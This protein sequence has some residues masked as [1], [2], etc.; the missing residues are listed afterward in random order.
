MDGRALPLLDA[1][2]VRAADVELDGHEDRAARG[3]ERQHFGRVGGGRSRDRAHVPTSTAP[4]FEDRD[5]ERVDL[6][7]EEHH[8][9][10]RPRC[11]PRRARPEPA[12]T[13]S[14]IN[15]CSVQ[16]PPLIDLRRDAGERHD[17]ADLGGVGARE[18]ERGHVVL[19]PVVVRGERRGARE[20]DGAV[21]G[22]EP[23]HA[24]ALPAGTSTRSAAMRVSA[25][26]GRNRA[27][28]RRA[29]SVSSFARCPRTPDGG[30]QV[31]GTVLADSERDR[32]RGE[33]LRDR[34]ADLRGLGRLAEP[35]ASSPGTSP[36]TC[37][38]IPVM[39]SPGW[40]STSAL[41]LSVVGACPAFARPLDSAI[42]KQEA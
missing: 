10:A 16:S 6:R 2:G 18:L 29:M 38:R 23:S 15:R 24:N 31:P 1:L 27:C 12:A 32:H 40:K 41:V 4:P 25:T 30:C 5:V 17:R 35:V 7:L 22:D 34:A 21:R 42:E 37:R 9:T 36:E 8:R 3:V 26:L 20:A 33:R 28:V 39:P 13:V 19:D 14:R 11:P